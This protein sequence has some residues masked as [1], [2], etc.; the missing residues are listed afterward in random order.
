MT[1]KVNVSVLCLL[2]YLLPSWGVLGL[3]KILGVRSVCA[4]IC[5]SI[6]RPIMICHFINGLHFILSIDITIAIYIFQ[7]SRLLVSFPIK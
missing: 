6:S 1:D 3:C 7:Y 4:S 5:F 2:F